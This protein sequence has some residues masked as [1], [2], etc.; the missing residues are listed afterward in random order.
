MSPIPG[1]SQPSS[2]CLTRV[3]PGPLVT[4]VEII[5]ARRAVLTGFGS[6][7]AFL[8]LFLFLFSDS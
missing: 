1:L 6:A 2:P 4:L 7:T 3:L 8:F 5:S